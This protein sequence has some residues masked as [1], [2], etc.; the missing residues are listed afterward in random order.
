MLMFAGY[1]TSGQIRNRIAEH[2]D[3]KLLKEAA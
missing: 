3:A 2:H 1:P